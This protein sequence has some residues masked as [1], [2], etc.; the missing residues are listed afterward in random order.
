[1]EVQSIAMIVSPTDAKEVSIHFLKSI[2]EQMTSSKMGRTIKQ[3][4]ILL[5]K[6]TKSEII[7]CIDDL[8]Q[9]GKHFYSLGYIQAVIDKFL[10][11]KQINLIAKEELEKQAQL[12]SSTRESGVIPD[13]S[14]RRNQ[15]KA[16]NHFKSRFG[17]KFDFNMLK[18]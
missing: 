11:E 2:N 14:T 3:A 12:I 4:K 9:Q 17:K 1:M 16:R 7:E 15:E 6:Y 10:E 13:E 5:S 8:V 18:E